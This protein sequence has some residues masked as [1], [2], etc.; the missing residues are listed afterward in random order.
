MK[1]LIVS[2]LFLMP[3]LAFAQSFKPDNDT[4]SA[5]NDVPAYLIDTVVNSK[6]TKKQLYSNAL[7]YLTKSFKDSRNV[8]EMKDADL[9]ELAF[10]GNVPFY[11][12]DTTVTNR[13]KKGALTEVKQ[14]SSFLVFKCKVYVKDERFKIVLSH[15][16]TPAFYFEQDKLQ[17]TL[18]NE[19]YKANNQ[20]ARETALALIKH[21]ASF[22]NRTPENEF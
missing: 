14:V 22:L 1:K 3:V 6:L 17:L 19:Y 2:V 8:V 12:S 7:N 10:S 11:Y 5:F 9:G 18:R 4:K 13:K 20:S 21:I 16:K 15:L